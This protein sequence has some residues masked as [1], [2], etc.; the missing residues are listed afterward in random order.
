MPQGFEDTAEARLPEADR[1]LPSN[2]RSD[3][4]RWWLAVASRRTRTPNW[5]IASTC[6]IEGKAGILLIEAKAHDNELLKEAA[7]KASPAPTSSD[8][9]QRNHSRIGE[10]IRDAN[11]ALGGDTGL[12]WSLSRDC[13]YQMSNRF[14]WAW[15]VADLGIPVV[16]VYLGFLGASEMSDRGTP[17]ADA[18]DWRNLV[19]RQS[20]NRI[21]V[22]AW[23]RRWTCG[24]QTL[25]PL[26]RVA[27]VPLEDKALH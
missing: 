6:T 7:G 2:V 27:Q 1:L 13:H 19:K 12:T 16:L 4:K 9:S 8:D 24:G 23:D 14:A 5:D 18:A 17:F 22:A 3:L 21:P 15:K 26:I 20:L 11:I 10:A 25:V